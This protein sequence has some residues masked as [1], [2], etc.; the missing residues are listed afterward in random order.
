[1]SEEKL[2]E[3]TSKEELIRLLSFKEYKIG[4]LEDKLRK[5]ETILEAITVMIVSVVSSVVTLI[6]MHMFS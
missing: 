6:V 5:K 4:M 3:N 2:N 1:M